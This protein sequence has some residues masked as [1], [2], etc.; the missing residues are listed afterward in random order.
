MALDKSLIV[1]VMLFLVLVIA[2][3]T[4]MEEPSSYIEIG[5]FENQEYESVAEKI[6]NT[7]SINKVGIYS[8]TEEGKIVTQYP[9]TGN[10]VVRGEEV[11]LFVSLGV[12]KN[13]LNVEGLS[14]NEARTLLDAQNIKY[15]IERVYNVSIEKEKVIG[16]SNADGTYTL[17]VS[18]GRPELKVSGK[19]GYAVKA[20][21]YIFYTDGYHLYQMNPDGSDKQQMVEVKAMKEM[22]PYGDWLIYADEEH[23]TM[24]CYNHVKKKRTTLARN[25]WEIYKVIDD[26]VIYSTRDGLKRKSLLS[27]N[28]FLIE[29]AKDCFLAGYVCTDSKFYYEKSYKIN[30]DEFRSDIMAIDMYTLEK[31]AVLDKTQIHRFYYDE[32]IAYYTDEK[33]I[34][35]MLLD[36]EII[37]SFPIDFA[38]WIYKITNKNI[39]YESN[40][41]RQNYVH[42][43]NLDTKE[44]VLLFKYGGLLGFDQENEWYYYQKGNWTHRMKSDGSEAELFCKEIISPR[45]Y[46]GTKYIFSF[47]DGLVFIDDWIYYLNDD[48]YLCRINTKTKEVEQ[49]AQKQT[50]AMPWWNC[51]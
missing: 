10:E 45:C 35:V 13:G 6:G 22:I 30:S 11:T 32:D 41:D 31:K 3:C 33:N 50:D 7:L 8:A 48:Y 28:E 2:G 14:I 17:Y 29:S 20:G 5:S 43:R 39:I 18:K 36:G 16:L 21:G 19:P 38:G 23:A 15:S 46:T 51:I 27:G 37:E 12:P 34:H 25:V 24:Y 44:E 49:L 42:I 4:G 40:V 26:H 47:T 1:G 9:Y